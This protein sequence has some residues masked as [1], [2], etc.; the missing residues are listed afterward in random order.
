MSTLEICVDNSV[1]LIK[2]IEAG[3]DRIELCSA[4]DVGGLTPTSNL[5][6]QA[7]TSS[8]PVYAMI[9][10]R[11]GNFVY[12]QAEI[13]AMEAD[14]A[15]VQSAGLAGVVFGALTEDRVLDQVAL[16]RLFAAASGLGKTLHRAVDD[17]VSPHEAVPVAIE[18]GFERIL[19]SGGAAS[20]VD[21]RVE[22][23]KMLELARDR[24]EIMAGSGVAAPNIQCLKDV[25]IWS[26]HGSCRTVWNG[27]TALNTKLLD[28][29]LKRIRQ[30]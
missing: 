6:E 8:I 5:I 20:A 26:F 22:L 24:I 3:V 18:I 16:T 13:M 9:R 25:G 4:L 21:G 30:P 19:T 14:I 10:P 17:M 2:A 7:K 12:S 23:S 11:G 28:E 27:T 1:D 15:V 29:T